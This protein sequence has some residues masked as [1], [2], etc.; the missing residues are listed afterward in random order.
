[1]EADKNLIL[2]IHIFNHRHESQGRLSS[3]I[4]RRPQKFGKISLFVL[5]L[6]SNFK[7]GG[8]FFQTLWP[9]HNIWILKEYIDIFAAKTNLTY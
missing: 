4:L 7:K 5:T 2:L 9:P 1:M 8:L 6:R 3:N